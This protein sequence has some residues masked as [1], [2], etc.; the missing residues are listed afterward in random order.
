M[1]VFTRKLGE[2]IQIGD[3]ISVT[4]VRVS[5]TEVRLGIEAP[6]GTAVYRAEV[7]A[8]VRI[9]KINDPNEPLPGM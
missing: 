7:R 3:N 8:N 5:P 9:V 4:V 2:I 1:L 6:A